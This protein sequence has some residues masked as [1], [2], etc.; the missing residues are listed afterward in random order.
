MTSAVE[1]FI[2][3]LDQIIESPRWKDEDTPMPNGIDELAMRIND[4]T[5]YQ[6]YRKTKDFELVIDVIESF[7][8]ALNDD[9]MPYQIEGLDLKKAKSFAIGV[10]DILIHKEPKEY[11]NEIIALHEKTRKN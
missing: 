6:S 10:R 4:G 7:E 9:W 5:T 8:G 11:Q 1:H 3:T 2:A